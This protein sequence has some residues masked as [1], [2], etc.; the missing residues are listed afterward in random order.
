MG[1]EVVQSHSGSSYVGCVKTQGGGGSWRVQY[2]VLFGPNT[3]FWVIVFQKIDFLKPRSLKISQLRVGA[4]VLKRFIVVVL[5][6]ELVCPL[7][8]Y[9]D[10]RLIH[11][12]IIGTD[13]YTALLQSLEQLAQVWC[14]EAACFV[15]C[16]L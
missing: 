4:I 9:K 14:Q 16:T 8:R 10:L 15:H 13:K 7:L 6:F 11:L 2:F 12:D 5:E 1:E 3:L